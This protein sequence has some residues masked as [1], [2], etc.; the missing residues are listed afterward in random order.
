ML[1][2]SLELYMNECE[3]VSMFEFEIEFEI[4]YE[5]KVKAEDRYQ[6]LYL[7][8]WPLYLVNITT[9]SKAL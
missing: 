2:L 6:N 3:G 5:Y 7:N 4:F 9:Q 8:I 1:N